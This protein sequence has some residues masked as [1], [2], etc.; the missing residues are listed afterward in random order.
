MR[1]SGSF[2]KTSTI[3][4]TFPAGD[5]SAFAID[6]AAA[7]R[8]ALAVT[9][10]WLLL[11]INLM[12]VL[13]VVQR[14]ESLCQVFVL[15]GLWAYLRG[16]H[17]M[18]AAASVRGERAGF[19]LATA[20]LILGTG[21]GLLSKESAVLLPVYAFLAEWTVLGFRTRQGRIDRR[22]V[23]LFVVVLLLPT[24]LGLLWLVPRSIAPA[25]WEGRDFTLSQRLLSEAR[26]LVD[27]LHWIVLPDPSTLSVYHDQIRIS[28]GLL[29][30]WTTLASILLLAALLALA[31][32]LRRRLPLVALG[33]LW[34]FAGQLLTATI[35]PLELV[36]EHRNYFASIGVLLALF[37]LLL[38]LRRRIAL[39]IVRGALVL[40]LL[41]WYG[42]VT[43]LRAQDWSNP[44]RL[45]LAEANRHPDSARANYEAGRLLIIAS[46]YAPGDTLDAARV[47]LRRAAAIPG[48]STLP[49]QALIMVTDHRVHGDDAAYWQS[50]A[51]KLRGQPT[52]QEDI[53]ALISLTQ[54][55]SKG[56]CH[57]DAP[58]L[59]R[60][61][62]AAL[63]RPAPNARLVA[64]YSDF[65]RD[66][67][68]DRQTAIRYMRMAVAKAP[69]ETAY[70]VQLAYLLAQDGQ[71][72]EAE[73][74]IRILRGMNELGR[75][76]AQIAALDGVLA[77]PVRDR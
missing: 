5:G 33:I 77:Q 20:G 50:M 73:K 53:S 18:L 7:Q 44:L 46:D 39:P 63:S 55:R 12:G 29:A 59:Q 17:R 47:Y 3:A 27:Y 15:A 51:I 4:A 62:L 64:G 68:H 66:L 6:E 36:Y 43:F 41:F 74:Q 56:D 60:A 58:P 76:D 45:A 70:R 28:T 19:A 69:G 22:I 21:V 48:A 1:K 34:F 35:V 26:I 52:R 31:V 25:A 49:E 75:L 67:L 38:G 65:A 14:M 30:P 72:A 61:Y 8:I 57:F 10:A 23:A 13:Y 32:A 2:S 54:C 24:V 42:S 37:S 71:T 11:P 16:R 40:I 9:A